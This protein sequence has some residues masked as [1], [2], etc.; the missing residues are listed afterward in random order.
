MAQLNYGLPS[1]HQIGHAPV[2][3][4]EQQLDNYIGMWRRRKGGLPAKCALLLKAISDYP[5]IKTH[6]AR[7]LADDCS[8]VPNQVALINRKLMNKGYMIIR[9]DPVGV[10]HNEDFHHWCIIEAPMMQLSVGMAVNDP[11]LQ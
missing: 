4:T 7:R 2:R 6:E 3:L 1:R 8:N 11:I 5:L 9:I 10:A